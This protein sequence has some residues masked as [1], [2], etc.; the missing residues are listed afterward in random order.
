MR[1][2][3]AQTLGSEQTE[4]TQTILKGVLDG[5]FGTRKRR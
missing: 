3:F 2:N 1:L 5:I 4:T